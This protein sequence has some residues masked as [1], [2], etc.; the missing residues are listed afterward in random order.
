MSF[1]EPDGRSPRFARSP[2]GPQRWLREF[3][4]EDW[5]LKLLAL[6]ITLGLWYGVTGQR[7][8]IT[9]RLRGVLLTFRLPEDMQ[10][11][12]DPRSEVEVTL[13]GNR[14]ALN[15]VNARDLVAYVDVTD[16]K[17]GERV[18]KL[19]AGRVKLDLP[20][21]VRLESIEPNVVPLR[22]ELRVERQI[23]V[24]AR[25][26]GNPPDGYQLLTV[27]TI[28]AKVRVRGPAS[29]IDALEKVPTESIS[30]DGRRESF[31]LQQVAIDI[32]DPK[33]DAVDSAVSVYVRVGERRTEKTITGVAVHASSG[34]QARPKTA[35]VL[36][37]G[38]RSMIN[39]L[40]P[41]EVRIVLD[42]TADGT[43]A[44][45][46]VLPPG[47]EGLVELR[48]TKPTHFSIK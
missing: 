32:P 28:P 40:R 27:N 10:I 38:P 11:S 44:P 34:G 42:R 4:L 36:L 19:T 16:R 7:T 1:R 8:P 26:E 14:K 45:H 5:N 20:E 29:H 35:S 21:G 46:L 13:T 12:N 43:P 23:E 33:V 47:M 48:S 39:S 30:L 3:F 22:L 41:E 17:P 37:D 25:L 15:Q 2:R 6:A 24:E 18:V 9:V 31:T